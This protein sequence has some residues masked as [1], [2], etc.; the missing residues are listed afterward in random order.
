MKNGF[1]YLEEIEVKK[2][3]ISEK[4]SIPDPKLSQILNGKRKLD[5]QR[6]IQCTEIIRR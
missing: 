6:I 1:R 4:A 3:Y 2:K 5:N